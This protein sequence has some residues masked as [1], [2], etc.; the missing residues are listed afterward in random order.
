[1]LRMSVYVLCS[2]L[3]VDEADQKATAGQSGG[4]VASWIDHDNLEHTR[5]SN[6]SSVL[7][8]P[9]A[10]AAQTP[11]IDAHMRHIQKFLQAH[12]DNVH[13][14]Q[15]SF[16]QPHVAVIAPSKDSAKQRVIT[17]TSFSGEWD[18]L[19]QHFSLSVLTVR[20]HQLLGGEII[21]G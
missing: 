2:F 1:M 12:M 15:K 11:L 7:Y 17:S 6:A 8:P 20:L 16:G 18:S 5:S 19:S 9:P 10:A 13:A 3:G 4:N 21:T 14:L